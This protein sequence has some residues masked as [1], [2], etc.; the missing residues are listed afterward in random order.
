MQ[1]TSYDLP[2]RNGST[3]QVVSAWIMLGLLSLVAAGIFSLLLVLARTPVI[4][5]LIPFA[6]F[7]H[8]ALVVHVNLS[9]LVWLLAMTAAMWSQD[10][11][12]QISLPWGAWPAVLARPPRV[13]NLE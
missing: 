2:I 12:P 11:R 6:D 1:S 13:N 8:I 10:A 3:R 4:Q 9:V 7:F 5:T